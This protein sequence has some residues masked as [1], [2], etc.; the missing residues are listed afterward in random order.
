MPTIEQQQIAELKAQV[1]KQ[2]AQIDFILQ[3]LGITYVYDPSVNDDPRVI[4]ALRKG[5]MIEAIKIYREIHNAGLAEA[6]TAVE[7]LQGRLG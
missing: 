7:E 1:A 6:K 2:K 3:H 4:E 5:G